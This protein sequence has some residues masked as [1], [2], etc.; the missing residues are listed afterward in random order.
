MRHVTAAVC[1]DDKSPLLFERLTLEDPRPD[2]LI[3]EVAYCGIC[4]TDISAVQ[5]KM[6]SLKPVVLGHEGA[7]VVVQVGADVKSVRP[8]DRV[9]MT[10]MTCGECPQCLGGAPAYCR[11]ARPLNMNAERLDHSTAF[12]ASEVHSHFFGQSSFATYSLANKRNVV[13]VPDDIPLSSAAALGCGVMTGTS[14]VFNAAD[15]RPGGAVLVT[16]TGAVGLSAVMAAR[17]CGASC[18]IGVDIVPSRLDLARQLGATHTYLATDPD[19]PAKIREASG[20]GINYAIEA[21][22]N[23]K[24]LAPALDSLAQQG[25]VVI[26][27]AAG[28]VDGTFRWRDLQLRGATIRGSVIGDANPPIFMPRLFQYYREGRFPVERLIK[29]YDFEAINEAMHDAEAGGTIK[30]VLR[31]G[32]ADQPN[33]AVGS[34][35]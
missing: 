22:G 33:T 18:I 20:G 16:G 2:E 10:N 1:R 21:S 8:G 29:L 25:S 35:I 5:G 3:I 19:L 9:M 28:L 15:V 26:V 6:G 30:P 23:V 31:I 27:G 14:A 34:S 13:K 32:E 12:H 17:I 7:G 11:H 4:H 24:A